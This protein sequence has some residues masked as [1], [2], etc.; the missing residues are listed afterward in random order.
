MVRVMII[1]GSPGTA[2]M[3]AV[4]PVV[5]HAKETPSPAAGEGVLRTVIRTQGAVADAVVVKQKSIFYHHVPFSPRFLQGLSSVWNSY[6]YTKR[7]GAFP[8]PM[9]RKEE[10]L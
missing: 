9:D 4:R 8:I 7:R 1:M 2:R 10:M 6:Q 5:R 3:A